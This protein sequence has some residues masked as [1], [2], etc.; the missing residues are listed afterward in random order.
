MSIIAL[1][2]QVKRTEAENGRSEVSSDTDIRK[3]H[4]DCP[5]HPYLKVPTYTHPMNLHLQ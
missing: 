3:R 5:E 4:T 1:R 2:A